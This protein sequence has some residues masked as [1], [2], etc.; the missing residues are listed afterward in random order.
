MLRLLDT[1]RALVHA[2]ADLHV[3]AF[4]WPSRLGERVR[5]SLMAPTLAV[6]APSCG[7]HAING[8]MIVPLDAIQLGHL[9]QGYDGLYGTARRGDN[10]RTTH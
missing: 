6:G 5:D 10:S 3:R 1:T 9:Q 4:S 8:H 2:G 7:A